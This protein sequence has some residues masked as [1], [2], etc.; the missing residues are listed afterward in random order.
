LHERI[1]KLPDKL[2]VYP[3]HGAPAVLLRAS[4]RRADDDDR[5]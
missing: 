4:R 2:P 3:N 1:L 5:P